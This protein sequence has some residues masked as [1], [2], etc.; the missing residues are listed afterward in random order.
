MKPAAILVISVMAL[1]ACI[2]AALD[3]QTSYDV[4]ADF[5][6][7]VAQPPS[8]YGT[9]LW[10][11]DEEAGLWASRW[12]ELAP[13][14]VRVSIIHAIVEPANDNGDPD[15]IN[16][17]GFLLNTP[18]S[19]PGISR[20]GTYHAW[21]Q[22]LRDQPDLNILICFEY[23]APWLS[24]NSPQPGFPF[25][26][27][28]YPP[29][30]LAEYREFVEAV[31]RYLVETLGFPP[32]RI[33]VEVM[34]EPDLRCGV[35]PVVVCFWE[36]W[37]MDDIADVVRVTHEA[38]LSVNAEIPLVGLAECCGV[39]VV[40]D[41]LDNYP[42]GAYLDGLSYH[43]YSPSGFALNAALSRAAT[44]ASYSRPIYLDEYGSRQYL[45]EGVGGALWHSWALTT[46]WKAGIAPLQYPVS[47]FPFQGEPYNSMG[48]FRDWRGDWV[49][50]PAYWVYVNFFHFVGGGEVISHTSPSEVDVLTTRRV[51]TDEVQ[52]TFW[53]VNR[54]G[55]KL[56]DQSFAV[57][58]FPRQE[59]VLLVYDNLVGPAPVLT[60]TVGGSPLVFTATLPAH[61]SRA[62]VLS[63][64][65]PHG[66]LDHVV[67][68]PDSATRVA[69]QTISY[70]LTAYDVYSNDWD[71][72][73][74]GTYTITPGAGGSWAGSV[75]TTEVAGAWTVTGSCGGQSDAGSLTVDHAG[76]DRLDLAPVT[77]TRMAGQTISYTLT[78]YDAY[79][80][81]WDVTTSGTYT[82]EQGAGGNWAGNV[83]TTGATGTWAV[84][85]AYG[86]RSDTATLT[87][88]MPTARVYLPLI[89]REDMLP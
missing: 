36:N 27:A 32:D 35:D 10:W 45:S 22:A 3:S 70:T 1:T 67:L 37:T 9:N 78:A 16:W 58:D 38:I 86:D 29:N 65:Q 6:A 77:A 55:T 13:S 75:Y 60:T 52:A 11:T 23:L 61:S 56:A 44:L 66:S 71:V 48:L 5:E 51:A 79:S 24:D 17:D 12:A 18:I 34:N 69:G 26:V 8:A 49:R 87:V 4:V 76:L 74:S 42:E 25:D 63:G 59:A 82:I 64:G 72:T 31:L 83:Y 14:M 20:T 43:Y 15:V 57:C 85:G 39:A 80:N 41:L 89:L 62:F 84:T 30:D 46:L 54:G 19:L 88:W 50:K 7:V 81:D 73:V 2:V 40:Q 53:V 33:A 21:L 47:E 68:T 28:P